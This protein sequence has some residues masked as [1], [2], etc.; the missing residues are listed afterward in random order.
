M[1]QVSGRG[2][3]LN[4]SKKNQNQVAGKRAKEA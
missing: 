2:L 4:R 3:S 1:T